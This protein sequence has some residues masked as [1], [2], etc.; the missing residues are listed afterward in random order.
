MDI[1]NL[2]IGDAKRLAAMFGGQSP[3]NKPHP[4][5]GQFVIVRSRNAGVHTGTLVAADGQ[6]VTLADARRLWRWRGANTLNEVAVKGVSSD[7]TRLSEPV[8]IIHITE[9]CEIIPVEPAARPSLERSQW[10]S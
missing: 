7:W 10:P 6:N 8:P 2:T 4:A 5:T 3:D 1:D 9:S